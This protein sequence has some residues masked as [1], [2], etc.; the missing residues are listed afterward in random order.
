MERLLQGLR[1][2]W[3]LLQG[4]CTRRLTAT[5]DPGTL[6]ASPDTLTATVS[7]GDSV[8]R[9]GVPGLPGSSSP[10]FRLQRSSL[11]SHY[12][13]FFPFSSVL[14]LFSETGTFQGTCKPPPA[15]HSSS[16]F[17]SS[18]ALGSPF[19]LLTKVSTWSACVRARADVGAQLWGDV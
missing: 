16:S 18:A 17:I 11:S 1:E 2:P 3:L 10:I 15:S 12:I 14:F 4:T 7:H 8:S 6:G 5:C 19:Y 13:W 9:H